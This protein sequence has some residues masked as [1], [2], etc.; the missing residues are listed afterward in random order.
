MT[1]D[2][3]NEDLTENLGQNQ[4]KEG[5]SPVQDDSSSELVGRYKASP[6]SLSIFK[7]ETDNGTF[8]QAVPQRVYTEDDG[9]SFDYTKT[10]RPRDLRKLARLAEKAADD[11]DQV[12]FVEADSGG[13]Q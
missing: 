4:E 5:K 3:Q 6:V 8:H 12:E 11:F 7:R 13:G 10:F 2:T 1:T 9:D